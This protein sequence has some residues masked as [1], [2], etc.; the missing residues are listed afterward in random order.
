MEPV[1]EARMQRGEVELLGHWIGRS[2]GPSLRRTTPHPV[3]FAL[4]G[5]LCRIQPVKRSCPCISPLVQKP[6]RTYENQTQVHAYLASHYNYNHDI[7]RTAEDEKT[8]C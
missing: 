4:Y 8:D 2:V 6:E 3:F 7:P 5:T 1:G